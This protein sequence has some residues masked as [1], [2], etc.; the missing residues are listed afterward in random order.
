MNTGEDIDA[1]AGRRIVRLSR[2]VT[3]SGVEESRVWSVTGSIVQAALEWAQGGVN[4]DSPDFYVKRH[5]L[6]LAD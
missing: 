4:R 2:L 5:R 3:R 6:G 1:E